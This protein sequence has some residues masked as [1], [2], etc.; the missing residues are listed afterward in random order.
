MKVRGVPV[1]KC[2]SSIQYSGDRVLNNP[3]VDKD[4]TVLTEGESTKLVPLDPPG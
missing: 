2:S 4:T 1:S 3:M